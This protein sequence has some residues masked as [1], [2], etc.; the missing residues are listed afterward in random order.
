MS[1]VVKFQS[2]LV[3]FIVLCAKIRNKC[4]ACCVLRKKRYIFEVN[5]SLKQYGNGTNIQTR[6]AGT[7][8]L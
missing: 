5:Q 4:S 3:Y 2:C 8:P 6:N 7:N 1:S